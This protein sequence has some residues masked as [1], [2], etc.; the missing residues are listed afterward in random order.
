MPIPSPEL[1]E[2]ISNAATKSGNTP[3]TVT[4]QLT[5]YSLGAQLIKA[6]VQQNNWDKSVTELGSQIVSQSV[7]NYAM[8]FGLP[9]VNNNPG[10][11]VQYISSAAA[12]TIYYKLLARLLED[13][14]NVINDTNLILY[15]FF[16]SKIS[17]DA[18][19][20]GLKK[21]REYTEHMSEINQYSDM[22]VSILPPEYNL[23]QTFGQFKLVIDNINTLC[24]LCETIINTFIRNPSQVMQ[25][26]VQYEQLHETT[27][28]NIPM[29]TKLF[30]YLADQ[31][32]THFTSLYVEADFNK[33]SNY[34]KSLNDIM[35]KVILISTK[36]MKYNPSSFQT[37]QGILDQLLVRFYVITSKMTSLMRFRGKFNE[38]IEDVKKAYNE[39]EGSLKPLMATLHAIAEV[40]PPPYSAIVTGRLTETFETLISLMSSFNDNL[41]DVVYAIQKDQRFKQFQTFNN[42]FE[43]DLTQKALPFIKAQVLLTW[44]LFNEQI[45]TDKVLTECYG[46]EQH[47]T[48]FNEDMTQIIQS[49]A[50]PA[51]Q[52]RYGRQRANIFYEYTQFIQSLYMLQQSKTSTCIR[53]YVAMCSIRLIF[54][55]C[56]LDNDPV[57]IEALD[58]VRAGL[59]LKN[60]SLFREEKSTIVS[61][62][63]LVSTLVPQTDK[64]AQTVLAIAVKVIIESEERMPAEVNQNDPESIV[65]CLDQNYNIGLAMTAILTVVPKTEQTQSVVQLLD[66]YSQ[67]FTKFSHGYRLAIQM[68]AMHEGELLTKAMSQML[69]FISQGSDK[70][71]R[72]RDDAT[73]SISNL[74]TLLAKPPPYGVY[75]RSYI[76]DLFKYI[77]AAFKDANDI[78][79]E[80]EQIF[81]NA[82]NHKDVR[83]SIQR[84]AKVIENITKMIPYVHDI[85]RDSNLEIPAVCGIISRAM[86]PGIIQLINQLLEDPVQH[87]VNAFNVAIKL[88]DISYMISSFSGFKNIAMSLKANAEII[89]AVATRITFGDSTVKDDLKVALKGVEDAN[90]RLIP[91]CDTLATDILTA[92]PSN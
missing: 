42:K 91:I 8:V 87:Y 76:T 40:V 22:E 47:F 10:K 54:A 5:A 71:R 4:V 53:S 46:I 24:K 57:I 59:A 7:L 31:V 28:T 16:Q 11:T 13:L 39:I 86:I 49:T 61:L 41:D 88:V 63:E 64:L 75:Y 62:M 67:I 72:L 60:G 44:N 50:S 45:E 6:T 90:K 9:A 38:D 30:N 37:I 58:A 2:A 18:I 14:G 32:S 23:Q 27:M 55:L 35:T 15:D 52:K 92:Q 80:C 78:T 79:W 17:S 33:F 77:T 82:P 70:S 74:N 83:Q 56:S 81:V 85:F 34:L 25:Y 48:K 89:D 12:I 3:E 84:C 65:Q 21:I 69:H 51:L 19:N 1:I 68:Q 36:L 43:S 26:Q 66:T 73:K 20:D 29:C